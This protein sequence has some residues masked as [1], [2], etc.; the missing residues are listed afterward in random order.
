MSP[1]IQ[2]DDFEWRNFSPADWMPCLNKVYNLHIRLSKMYNLHVSLSKIVLF[3]MG[4]VGAA[5]TNYNTVG[6]SI[7]TCICEKCATTGILSF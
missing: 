3:P 6:R 5:Y 1:A 2:A 7:Q 4:E